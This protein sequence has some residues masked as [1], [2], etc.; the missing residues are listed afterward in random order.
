MTKTEFLA[1]KEHSRIKY[2]G[3][4]SGILNTLAQVSKTSM[5]KGVVVSYIHDYGS[6]ARY[7][8]WGASRAKDVPSHIVLQLYSGE[9]FE[10]V[11]PEDWVVVDAKRTDLVRSREKRA[12]KATDGRVRKELEAFSESFRKM[13]DVKALI[14]EWLNDIPLTE[15]FKI[16]T[17]LTD[18]QKAWLELLHMDPE[19]VITAIK[20]IAEAEEVSTPVEVVPT[21]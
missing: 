15:R 6:K 7:A 3:T 19:E 1:V 9:D 12:V 21:T 5:T 4:D 8:S 13:K 2:I 18:E 20:K 16:L 11:K 10:C 14:D 17:A